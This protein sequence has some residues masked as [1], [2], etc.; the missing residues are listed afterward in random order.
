MKEKQKVQIKDKTVRI[1]IINERS[2]IY[3][4]NAK[5]LIKETAMSVVALVSSK[6]PAGSILKRDKKYSN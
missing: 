1:K 4:K 3:R 2:K 6:L 5:L